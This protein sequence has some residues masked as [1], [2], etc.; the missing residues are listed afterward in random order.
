MAD[1][2][3]YFVLFAADDIKELSLD[4]LDDAYRL[5]VIDDSTLIW[6]EGFDGWKP[7]SDVVN[8]ASDEEPMDD[9]SAWADVAGSSFATASAYPY[10]GP[11]SA[12]APAS[13]APTSHAPTSYA[14]T[15]Y[16]PSSQY[17]ASGYASSSVYPQSSYPAASMAPASTRAVAY[18]TV[19]EP[20]VSSPWFRRVLFLAAAA[21]AL[22]VMQRSGFV[23]SFA[24]A[25]DQGKSAAR[26]EARVLG[27][28]AVDTPRGLD[29]RLAAIQAQY[30]LDH[31]SYTDPVRDTPAAK[32]AATTPPKASS[33][34]A[35]TGASASGTSATGSPGSSAPGTA[36]SGSVSP[37]SAAPNTATKSSEAAAQPSAPS[38]ADAKQ[39]APTA[40]AITDRMQNALSG[41]PAPKP[42]HAA[43]A[44]RP[45][46]HLK[47][48]VGTRGGDPNDPM[49]GSL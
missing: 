7:L 21:G 2:E 3:R 33:A 27:S 26:L 28:P 4:Q 47:L 5:D 29:A 22:V 25:L 17:P 37:A 24:S 31:L 6:Q 16:A 45:A 30:H 18:D 44:A 49:N 35:P 42:V 19:D 34:A 46:K 8:A 32:P 20:E 48:G 11:A 41:K 13:Y 40:D 36:A 10:P 39:A 9:V 43:K 14:P 23:Q 1:E 38:P 15:S 12:A